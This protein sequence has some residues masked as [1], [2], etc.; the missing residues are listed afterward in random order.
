VVGLDV[1]INRLPSDI[2]T[3]FD[4]RLTHYEIRWFWDFRKRHGN[5]GPL[6]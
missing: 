3:E 1:G 2:K 5:D 6:L 4:W